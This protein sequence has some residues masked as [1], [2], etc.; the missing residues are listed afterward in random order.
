MSVDFLMILSLVRDPLSYFRS[1]RNYFVAIYAVFLLFPG[2]DLIQIFLPQNAWM[3]LALQGLITA[4]VVIAA[5][6]GYVATKL[7]LY[8]EQ[9]SLRRI[10]SKPYRPI[11]PVFVLYLIPMIL[12]VL[13]GWGY[14]PAIL[15]DPPIQVTYV[16]QGIMLPSAVLGPFLLG[17]GASV[18]VA[19]TVYPFA[20]LTRLRSQIKDKE[21]RSA[22]KVFGSAFSAIAMTLLLSLALSSFGYSISGSGNFVSVALIIVAVRAFRK[23]TFLKAFLGVLPSL[24]SSPAVSHIDQ[25]IMIY[26]QSD[27]KYGPISRYIMDGISQKNRVVYFHQGDEALVRDGLSHQGID[28]RHYILKGSLRFFPLGGIYPTRSTLDDTPIDLCKQLASE[29]RI[30]GKDGLQVILDYDDFIVRPLQKFIEHLIDPRW[31]SRDHYIHLLMAFDS[32]T[33][34]GDANTLSRLKSSIRVL[35]LSESLDVFSRTVGLSHE[36]IAGG[37]ILV[38]YNPQSDYER[39]V[40]SLLAE[41]ASNFE[42]TVVFTRKNSPI[43]P[44]VQQQPGSK[45]FI[46]T[47]K[48]SYPTVE[49]ENKVL[50]PAY[51]SSLLLDALNKTIEAYEGGVF[52]IVFDNISHFIFTLGPER[53]HSLVRQALEMMV[54]N[55][56]TAIFLLN[57]G[58]HDTKTIST[59]ENMF[60][61]ELICEP[62]ARA[63]EVRKKMSM[64]PQ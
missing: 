63:P 20:V 6:W 24:E 50:L 11:F 59:F 27:E 19:F 29:A 9:F 22:L 14:S 44:L 4:G 58:A 18:V 30:L 3:R 23:P 10:I 57:S 34:Q 54:S 21:V 1:Y 33:F 55:R 25:T 48:V 46:L 38:E 31:T 7:Y 16:L 56:I 5:I 39:V 47:P 43:Y 41:A 26:R 2:S 8:P 52:N 62:G 17:V 51:D 53:S 49:S 35:E 13:V 28:V 32:T 61:I 40:K 37:K 12:G 64:G 36:A 60:D 42:R 15:T 45:I